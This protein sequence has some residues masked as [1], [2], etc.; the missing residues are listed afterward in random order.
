M[1]RHDLINIIGPLNAKVGK[2][3]FHHNERAMGKFDCG[4]T[5]NSGE[6]LV[7]FCSMNDLLIRGTILS[8]TQDVAF[9][10]WQDQRSL[11]DVRVW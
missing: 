7:D 9:P 8:H 2:I 5:N 1:A 11:Q 3:T 4:T 10:T 6:R